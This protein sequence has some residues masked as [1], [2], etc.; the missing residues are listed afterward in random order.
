MFDLF[1]VR[2][3][4]RIAGR[5]LVPERHVV[6]GRRLA[7]AG[8]V[9][10]AGHAAT[11]GQIPAQA[12]GPADCHPPS[13]QAARGLPPSVARVAARMRLSAELLAAILEVDGR[14][15]ATLDDME[16][17]DALADVLLARRRQRVGPHRP[18]LA[19]TGRG[20]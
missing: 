2:P 8:H 12:V 18:E 10:P 20:G 1:G 11:V 13:G 4:P 19:R 5:H 3:R 7:P 15:R 6:P 9:A 14:S 16:R 17:A